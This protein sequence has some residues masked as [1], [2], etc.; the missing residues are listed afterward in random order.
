MTHF[1]KLRFVVE[2]TFKWSDIKT[3]EQLPDLPKIAEWAHQWKMSFNPDLRKQ[4]QEVIFFK[5]ND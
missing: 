5:E 4:A 2:V 3:P 1:E